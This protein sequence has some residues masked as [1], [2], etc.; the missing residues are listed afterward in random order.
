MRNRGITGPYRSALLTDLY[1]LTMAYGYWRHGIS[2]REAVFYLSF[3]AHPFGG[4]Y[5]VACGLAHVCEVLADFQFTAS[6][7]DYLSSLRGAGETPLFA[8]EFL[9]YL[10]D[11]RFKGDVD[12]IEEGTLV[13]PH[14]PLLRVRGPLIQAQVVETLLLNTV[15]F[16]TLVA[17]KAAR[18]CRAAAPGSVLEFGLR[19]AQGAS[20]G[21]VAS[22]AA[23]VGGCTGTSNVLAGKRYGIPVRGTHAHSWVLAFESELEAFEK[24]AEAM[25]NNCILLVDTFDSEKGV[26]HAIEVARRMRAKGRELIGIRL[27]SGDLAALSRRAR[28]MLDEAGLKETLILA[29]GDLDEQRI[30]ALKERGSRIDAWG[31]GT[32]L[33]TAYDQPALGGVYKLS[34]LRDADGQWRHK[35]K[36]SQEPSKVSLPGL[37]Q[38]RRYRR[39]G[40]CVGDVIYDEMTGID[41]PPQVVFDGVDQFETPPATT[42]EDL[43]VP[44]FRE[45][46]Q[47]YQQPPV[48][49]IRERALSQLDDFSALVEGGPEGTGYPVCL[50]RRLHDTKERL[51]RAC[52]ET[53]R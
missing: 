33:A 24:Y 45:G 42:A 50:E 49:D 5:T 8:D 27:D 29:S 26:A 23:Y 19:R 20:G 22:R 39:D 37:L 25:P 31:V 35:L 34:A 3:R 4:E 44:V 30:A 1:E 17:T 9:E 41:E 13:F 48:E 36:V 21:V 6:D 53:S 47:V 43:L 32:R 52:E 28:A 7:T 11:L 38:V 40:R 10:G 12:A 2:E 51:M 16:S 15:N 18:V 14:Q 46:D